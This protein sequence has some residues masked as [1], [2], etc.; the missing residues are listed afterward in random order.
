M[1]LRRQCPSLSGCGDDRLRN[2]I[3]PALIDK[4]AL[5]LKCR[6]FEKAA[7][8]AGRALDRSPAVS[9]DNRLRAHMIRAKAMLVVGNTSF[10]K[11]DIESVL[12]ML[13]GP[14]SLPEGAVEML[15]SLSVELGPADMHAL[16]QASPAASLLLPLKTALEWEL[17]MEP[18]VAREVEEVARD[19]RDAWR[20]REHTRHWPHG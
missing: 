4:A 20:E 2:Q 19:I 9:C 12:A 15:M 14:G 18:R 1:L 7:E 6:R 10:C 16:I 13:P 5:E 11:Q 8:T 17:G 3:G